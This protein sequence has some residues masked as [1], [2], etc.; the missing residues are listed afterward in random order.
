LLGTLNASLKKLRWI[1]YHKQR[2][3]VRVEYEP[4]E[5]RH[6]RENVTRAGRVLA[7]A[8]A[9]AELASGLQHVDVVGAHVVLRQ[10]HDRHRQRLLACT[11]Y[12]TKC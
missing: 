2:V 5:R 12:H 9:R 10:V 3:I 6:K 7:A 11:Q 1:S 8:E 4:C